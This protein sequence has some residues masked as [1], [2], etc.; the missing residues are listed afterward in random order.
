MDSELKKICRTFKDTTRVGF[1]SKEFELIDKG[2]KNIKTNLDNKAIDKIRTNIEGKCIGDGYVIPGTVKL[3]KR[4]NISFPHEALQ[5]HYT[6]NIDYEYQLCNP[7]PGVMLNC[8]VVTANKIG[9]L[10]RLESNK[11]PLV[12][13]IPEDLCDTPG[14]KGALDLIKKNISNGEEANVSVTVIGKRFEQNDRKI[15]VIAEINI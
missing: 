12:I 3:L 7:N 8:K 4:S 1:N 9:I 13:L 5:L 2:N 10:A 14:K 15:T 6:M 11:S